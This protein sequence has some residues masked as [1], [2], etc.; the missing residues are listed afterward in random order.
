MTGKR[1]TAIL[2]AVA[3]LL[4]AGGIYATVH[5]DKAHGGPQ[6]AQVITVA[7]TGVVTTTPDRADFSF[8]VSTDRLTAT[9][10]LAATAQQMQRVINALKASGIEA[11]DIQTQQVSIATRYD[12]GTIVG[13]T[14]SNSV[15]A[16]VRDIDKAGAVID[17][18]V[19]AGATNVW[20]PSFFRSDHQQLTRSALRA[21]V[22]DARAKAQA[23]AAASG[24]SV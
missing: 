12:A 11:R 14:A 23:V 22:S 17:A 1:F 8:G 3:L 16:K 21:A 9:G 19:E 20:G 10:A 18:A 7:G 6:P 5:P 15:I 4:A 13:Y 24:V 2:G